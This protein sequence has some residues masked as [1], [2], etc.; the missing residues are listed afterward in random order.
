VSFSFNPSRG[1]ILIDASVS[2]PPG[3][4]ALRLILDTGATTSLVRATILVA[5]GYD[6]DASPDHVN[7]AMGNGLQIIPRVA[8]TRLSALG[9]HRLAVPVL[10]HS[11]PPSVGIDGRL[12]LDS[13]R[14]TVL[15]VDSD[16]GLITLT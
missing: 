7:V 2:G 9:Q 8:V 10:A 5:L 14:G 13:L 12:G 16:S 6:P 4:A 15:T 1:Q 11:L 3:Q